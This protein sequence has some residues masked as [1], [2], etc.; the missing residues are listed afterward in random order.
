MKICWLESLFSFQV[1]AS[2][3]TPQCDAESLHPSI[4][5]LLPLPQTE[6][7][8]LNGRKPSDKLKTGNQATV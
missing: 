4:Q 6:V 1:V 3:S 8:S 7:M 2:P 5:H